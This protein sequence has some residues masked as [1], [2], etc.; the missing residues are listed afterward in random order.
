[1]GLLRAEALL[2]AGRPD[3]ARRALTAARDLVRRTAAVITSSDLRQSYL[4]E[5]EPNRLILARAAE[6]LD[7]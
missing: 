5:V 1:M 6:W 3:D 7:D 2:V 4:S